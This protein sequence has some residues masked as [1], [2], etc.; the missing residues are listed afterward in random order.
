MSNPETPASQDAKP[1]T[2]TSV[3][4][5]IPSS[6]ELRHHHLH[7]ICTNVKKIEIQRGRYTLR[8][9]WTRCTR[10][11]RRLRLIS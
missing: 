3:G 9:C 11:T 4:V 2:R 8:L 5:Q 1:P 10:T 6:P 7:R